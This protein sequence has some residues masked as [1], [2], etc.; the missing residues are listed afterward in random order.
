MII[1]Y[2]LMNIVK[3]WNTNKDDKLNYLDL[4]DK[5]FIFNQFKTKK[6]EGQ[7]IM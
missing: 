1:L 6:T 4:D 3:K 7:Q 5:Q 2:L